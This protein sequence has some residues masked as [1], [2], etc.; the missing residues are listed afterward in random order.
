[1][2]SIMIC[3]VFCAV[4]NMKESF[5]E[6]D[7]VSIVFNDSHLQKNTALQMINTYY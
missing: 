5:S 7:S 1:M 3:D 6:H 4:Q 2:M